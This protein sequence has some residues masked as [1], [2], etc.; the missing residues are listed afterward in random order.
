MYLTRFPAR[1]VVFWAVG[2]ALSTIITCYLI[3][4]SLG[5]VAYWL[6]DITHCA[7]HAPERFI[8]RA[9]LIPACVL[10][11]YVWFLAT[12]W[13]ED[14]RTRIKGTPGGSAAV[15]RGLGVVGSLALVVSSSVLESDGTTMWT[16]HV[17][18]ASSFFLL[19]FVAQVMMTRELAKLR[20]K[21]K[22]VIGSGSMRAKIIVCGSIT[23][24]LIADAIIGI[25][26][27][28][29]T[30][31]NLCEWLMTFLIISYNIS[32]AYDFSNRVYS[33]VYFVPSGATD[34]YLRLPQDEA[35]MAANEHLQRNHPVHHPPHQQ[36]QQQQ[37]VYHHHCATLPQQQG[38]PHTPFLQYT[39]PPPYDSHHSIQY[40]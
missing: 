15:I 23:L 32:Y 37:H 19:T 35:T 21:N 28:P 11:A 18:C 26:K 14:E 20:K 1:N 10:L 16:L 5:H 13:L 36:Q 40:A 25:M 30:Y 12:S 33:A 39:T 27:L 2:L 8:F 4:T 17:I 6:P 9:G 34:G 31:S 22:Q 38:G 3:A 7:L 24:I 29:G